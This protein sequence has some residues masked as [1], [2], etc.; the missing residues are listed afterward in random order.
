M[1]K[2]KFKKIKNKRPNYVK[3]S[4]SDRHLGRIKQH[5]T[6]K[7]PDRKCLSRSLKRKYSQKNKS[8]QRANK[9]ETRPNKSVW[10]CTKSQHRL[11]SW[12]V[13]KYRCCIQLF[14]YSSV[15][16]AISF[17]TPW[18]HLTTAM[19]F[20]PLLLCCF[21]GL[22]SGGNFSLSFWALVV[23]SA[24]TRPTAELCF[25]VTVELAKIN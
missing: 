2:F 18:L 11:I 23:I 22:S 5:C 13:P 14:G 1:Q 6:N 17:Y 8:K 19:S 12:A 7:S 15:R 4:V 24:S 20:F 10:I 21:N 3:T 9:L 25:R 16:Y